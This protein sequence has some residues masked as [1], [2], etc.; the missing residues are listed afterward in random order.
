[1]TPDASAWRF[2]A[3]YDHVDVLASSD[4]AWEWL[5]RNDAYD[6]DFEALARVGADRPLLTERIRRRWRL[7][8]P[9]RSPDPA[10]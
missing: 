2:S 9:C 4:L 1:M 10:P 6:A 7:R 3:N 5:R 8:F